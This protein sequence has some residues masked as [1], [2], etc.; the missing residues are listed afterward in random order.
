MH[1]HERRQEESAMDVVAPE[2]PA[3]SRRSDAGIMAGLDADVL[4]GRHAEED[5]DDEEDDVRLSPYQAAHM[6][7]RDMLT[8]RA[9]EVARA[10]ITAD[11]ELV[12]A[13]GDRG[14]S[15]A[16]VFRTEMARAFTRLVAQPVVARA[17]PEAAGSRQ[18]ASA[19]LA[20][21]VHVSTPPRGYVLDM[22]VPDAWCAVAAA[23]LAAS[24]AVPEWDR[25]SVALGAASGVGAE[26]FPYLVEDIAPLV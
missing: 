3:R 15:A 10:G 26:L 24:T 11:D 17:L 7:L 19:A 6:L 8:P 22:A 12:A 25:S 20:A 5:E 16:D 21:V 9:L 18:R 14:A 4:D 23:V 2:P 1:V 13:A